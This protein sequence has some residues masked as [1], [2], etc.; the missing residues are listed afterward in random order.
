M[1]SCA[2]SQKE[3]VS[4]TSSIYGLTQLLFNTSAN[5]QHCYGWSLIVVMLFFGPET[6]KKEKARKE[7]LECFAALITQLPGQKDPI[8]G[9]Q[10]R[11]LSPTVSEMHSAT[12]ARRIQKLHFQSTALV[13][14]L[15][16]SHRRVARSQTTLIQRCRERWD[17]HWF[18][19][20]ACFKPSG[21]T[22]S[23]QDVI[24]CTSAFCVRYTSVFWCVWVW[25]HLLSLWQPINA[26]FKHPIMKRHQ[27][28]HT[29]E[30][31]CRKSAYQAL[32]AAFYRLTLTAIHNVRQ[33]VVLC[34]SCAL[35]NC[36]ERLAVNT[37]V[38]V[39]ENNRN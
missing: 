6:N 32:G 4:P 9:I 2:V 5:L 11:R 8:V 15:K 24:Y 39:G 37:G 34:Y 1:K 12:A 21:V 28:T 14:Q 29:L 22:C 20:S 38:G 13:L 23:P 16:A 3:D 17:G 27:H 7:I 36:C 30:R 26:K 10:N 19:C 35:A 31:I 18:F 33:K 25:K